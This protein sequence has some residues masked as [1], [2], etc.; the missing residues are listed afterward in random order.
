[1]IA[2]GL[3]LLVYVTLDLRATPPLRHRFLAWL[4]S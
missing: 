4:R 3:W 2:V 1:M